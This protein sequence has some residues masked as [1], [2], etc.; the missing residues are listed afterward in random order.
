MSIVRLF[1][2]QSALSAIV[3]VFSN[4]PFS[5]PSNVILLWF[6]DLRI[7]TTVAVV[8]GLFVICWSPFFTLNFTLYICGT[9]YKMWMTI[10]CQRFKKLLVEFVD[11][12]K[13]LQYGNSVCNPIIYGLRNEEFRRTFRKILLRLCCKK[14]RITGYDKNTQEGMCK[15]RSSPVEW[16]VC[17]SVHLRSVTPSSQLVREGYCEVKTQSNLRS[18]LATKSLADTIQTQNEGR[19]NHSF[20]SPSASSNSILSQPQY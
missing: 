13:W 18:V 2:Y 20:P 14:V 10:G 9:N 16:P 17:E 5:R 11:I 15:V 19:A 1:L 3:G 6:Q 12:T 4:Q 7:A 8:I